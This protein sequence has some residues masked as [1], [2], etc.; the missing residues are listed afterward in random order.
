[1]R[2]DELAYY[3]GLGFLDQARQ[4][5]T[6]RHYIRLLIEGVQ[7]MAD[8]LARLTVDV[9]T[10]TGVIAAANQLLNNLAQQIRDN[11][12]DPAALAA[13]ADQVEQ[14]TSELSNSIIQNTPA[15]DGPTPPT[16][17]DGQTT[18]S[19]SGGSPVDPGGTQAPNSPVEP[20]DG[21]VPPAPNTPGT[22]D[23]PVPPSPSTP[24]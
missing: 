2:N 11:Q 4:E 18:D 16:P 17:T 6:T 14:N 20:T 13:L 8:D 24:A 1:M 12:N 23:E 10:Q 19:N 21:G 7:T 15:N 22:F 5:H 3:I 9:T